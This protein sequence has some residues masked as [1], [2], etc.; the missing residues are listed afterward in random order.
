[1]Q[2]VRKRILGD[3]GEGEE[4]SA[5]PHN[6]QT[7]S[8]K[9]QHNA[10]D[11]ASEWSA[12]ALRMKSFSYED[13]YEVSTLW[14]STSFLATWARTWHASHPKPHVTHVSRVRNPRRP[15]PRTAIPD[16]WSSSSSVL[17]PTWISLDAR[18]HKQ[19]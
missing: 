11:R 15:C 16:H 10:R 2:P 14:I 12:E 19:F 13:S 18:D 7:R 6:T 8:S 17:P 1:M 3:H 9:E 4:L 5:D